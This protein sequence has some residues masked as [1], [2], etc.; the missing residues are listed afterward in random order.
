MDPCILDTFRVKLVGACVFHVF[1]CV[2]LVFS[3][4]CSKL[5]VYFIKIYVQFCYRLSMFILVSLLGLNP[6]LYPLVCIYYSPFFM[7]FKLVTDTYSCSSPWRSMF[8]CFWQ[9]VLEPVPGIL[10]LEKHV[11]CLVLVCLLERIMNTVI[12]KLV[13]NN[14]YHVMWLLI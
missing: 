1:P 5:H 12:N 14:Y 6:S 8:G 4:C 11:I 3:M 10:Y 9:S 2:F 13:A 7:L